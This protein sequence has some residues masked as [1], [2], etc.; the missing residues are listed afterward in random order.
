MGKQ[1]CRKQEI[2]TFKELL[3]SSS[4]LKEGKTYP[5]TSY[6]KQ[7]LISFFLSFL[8]FKFLNSG[9]LR[10]YDK[11]V[12]WIA[13]KLCPVESTYMREKERGGNGWGRE[14]KGGDFHS[15]L[16]LGVYFG[17]TSSLS[18]SFLETKPT[19]IEWFFL[20]LNYYFS[21]FGFFS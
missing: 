6:L 12:S 5:L 13:I 20:F 3:N 21:W 4:H 16:E 10:F 1:L 18:F 11:E 8:L 17:W 19:R 9:F 15:D 7:H 2:R 14:G